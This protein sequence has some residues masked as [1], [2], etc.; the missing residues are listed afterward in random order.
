MHI[1]DFRKILRDLR[2]YNVHAMQCLEIAKEMERMRERNRIL[3][4]E[5][6][7]LR[8]L[9]KGRIKNIADKF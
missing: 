4:N 7:K 9:T 2:N 3:T 5:N 8:K 6:R 1:S